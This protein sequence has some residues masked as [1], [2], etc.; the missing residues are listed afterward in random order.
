MLLNNWA[1]DVTDT[2]DM[3]PRKLVTA[4]L[5]STICLADI[6]GQT[7]PLPVRLCTPP[8][9]LCSCPGARS[10]C[11]NGVWRCE[12]PRETCNGKDDDCNGRIDDGGNALCNDGLSCTDDVCRVILRDP[13]V[14]G[15]QVTACVNT[16]R[17]HRC[18]DGA[19][20]TIDTC[21]PGAPNRDANG[22]VFNP[23][24]SVCDDG[25][26][27]T[28]RE[29]CSPGAGANA[30]TG[31]RSGTPPCERDGNVCTINA[32]CEDLSP[33]C[34]AQLGTRAGEV[35][36]F[37]SIAGGA[38]VAS[39]TGVNVRCPSATTPLNCDD[40]NPCTADYCSPTTGCGHTNVSDGT[41]ISRANEGCIAQ[42]CIGGRVQERWAN[43][44]NIRSLSLTAPT[45]ES[46]GPFAGTCFQHSCQIYTTS[47]GAAAYGCLP[48]ANPC[49]DGLFC[50]GAEICTL[51]GAPSNY[52]MQNGTT[53]PRGCF[54]PASSPCND[55]DICTTDVCNEAA[56]TCS[57][58][59][60]GFCA[61]D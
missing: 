28:G 43:P 56:N 45:C 33:A 31:C 6:K 23:R 51:S 35:E 58:T 34:R 17:N 24:D 38:T 8:A 22:C 30:A 42:V 9:P 11:A 15:R 5:L 26:N 50:N 32:C 18:N 16:P 46:F 1:H 4:F 39:E 40:G 13:T 19:S 49:S 61:L 48:Q 36:A 44:E 47:G 21:S 10:V 59:S 55:N 25:C 14:G 7:Q 12:N 54:R 53:P 41:V 37:C 60:S 52:R 2:A 57:H 27:C 20:C 3:T 29:V